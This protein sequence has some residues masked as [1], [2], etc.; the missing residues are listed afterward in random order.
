MSKLSQVVDSKQCHVCASN[1]RREEKEDGRGG[2]LY[3]K[4]LATAASSSF[5]KEKLDRALLA[6]SLTDD[7]E[8]QKK[9]A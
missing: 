7:E 4:P 6:Y 3:E 5:E 9:K 2:G 8:T 1:K